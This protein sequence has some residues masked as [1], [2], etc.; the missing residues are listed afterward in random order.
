M[1]GSVTIWLCALGACGCGAKPAA[2]PYAVYANQV[3]IY[4]GA[5]LQD[6]MGSMSAGDTPESVSDGMAWF[7]K[8]EAPADKLLAFYQR[9]LPD[10]TRDPRW[11]EGARLV[12]IPKGAAP[13]ERVEVIIENDGLRISE[14]VKPGKRPGNPNET[15]RE[16]ASELGG[17][18]GGGSNGGN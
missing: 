6:A 7:F 4:P 2:L 15:S 11:P 16:M 18:V 12:W 5:V 17:A 14:S 10:A 3:P 9:R 13:G 8:V 1:L